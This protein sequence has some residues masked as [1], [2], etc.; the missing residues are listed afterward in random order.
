MQTFEWILLGA[1]T[2][3]VFFP[4]LSGTRLRRGL[5][6]IVLLSSLI[7]LLLAHG[8]RWQLWPAYVGA[9]GLAIGDV[10]WEERRVRGWPRVRRGLAGLIGVAVVSVLPISLPIPDFPE[11][12]G[13]HAVG[14]ATFVLEDPERQER[15]GLPEDLSD[16][17]LEDIPARHIMVQVWYPAL[18][19]RSFP[20][21][22]WNPDWDVVGPA[23]ANRLGFPGF[24]LSHVADVEATARTGLPILSGRLP[25]VVY[26]HG[27]TGFRTIAVNQMESL[28]SHGY[29]VVA[30]DHAY[31]AIASRFPDRTVVPLDPRALPDEETVDEDDYQVASEDLVSTFTD[32]ITLVVDQLD[33]GLEGEFGELASSVDLDRLGVYGHSTGGGAAVRFCIEDDRCDA[34]LGHD[35]WVNPIPDRVVARELS[36]PSLFMR[37]DGWIDTPNDRRLRGLAERSESISYWVSVIGAGHNDFVATPLFS[38]LADRIGLKGPIDGETVVR[39]IDEYLIAFFDRYLYEIGGA[40]LDD[41]PPDEVI[42][43]FLP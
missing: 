36:Q 20:P 4:V 23:M 40:V 15:Y 42:L 3:A 33:A 14:T 34:V 31:G 9:L 38:P 2:L 16:E 5:M 24:F 28:A 11:P 29:V 22:V 17:E 7:G 35:A 21:E 43:E 6:A 32:D 8:S 1:I 18:D 39:I 10:L 25:V 19:D 26:S 41:P 30:P 12:S 37:S 27:W 13:P